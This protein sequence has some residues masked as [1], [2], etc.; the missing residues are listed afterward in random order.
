MEGVDCR[1]HSG[2]ASAASVALGARAY[3]S[4]WSTP[5][6]STR[7]G[8]CGI[9]N[10]WA[11][12]R[13]SIES[14]YTRG[15][16][17]I[18]LGPRDNSWTAPTL[19]WSSYNSSSSSCTIKPI[20]CDLS[21]TPTPPMNPFRLGDGEEAEGEICWRCDG[22]PRVVSGWASRFSNPC[23]DLARSYSL[24]PIKHA[25]LALYHILVS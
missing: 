6:L 24:H 7:G 18:I 11:R 14:I 21:Y 4:A 16:A 3:P 2:G 9:G 1:R 15:G 19:P 20:S 23:W 13:R 8:C 12:W 22:E 10:R 17:Y 25:I 5:Y